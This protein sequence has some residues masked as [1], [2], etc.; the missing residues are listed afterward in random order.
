MTA[1]DL[2]IDAIRDHIE[3]VAPT[4]LATCQFAIRDEA[5]NRAFPQVRVSERSIE[6][7]E[8]LLGVYRCTVDVTIR[9]I[10]DDTGDS[11]HRTMVEEL[12]N[13]VADEDIENS[14]TS[15]DTLNVHDARCSGPMTAPEDD[16]RETTL[17]LSCVFHTG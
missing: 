16:M 1:T 7:H 10:P 13:I 9:T 12:W 15:V 3:A 2:L 8:V 6:E 17:E 5:T 14:L 4:T 11:T